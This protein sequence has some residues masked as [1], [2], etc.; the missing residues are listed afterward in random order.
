ML[1]HRSMLRCEDAGTSY[2]VLF[3]FAFCFAYGFILRGRYH[4]HLLCFISLLLSLFV[5]FLLL[6]LLL[7]LAEGGVKV[8]RDM[9]SNSS[10]T[11][12]QRQRQRHINAQ[13][14]TR[15]ASFNFSSSFSSISI[16]GLIFI[17][18][19]NFSCD[20][21][22]IS[23]WTVALP[24]RPSAR[25]SALPSAR[26]TWLQILDRVA[27]GA[28]RQRTLLPRVV[29][30]DSAASEAH[31]CHANVHVACCIARAA[32]ARWLSTNWPSCGAQI[33]HQTG[34]IHFES[35]YCLPTI[36]GKLQVNET[37]EVLK[38]TEG[39]RAE[40]CVEQSG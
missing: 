25:P 22:P 31:F 29:K 21:S 18:I 24:A 13:R 4:L 10:A 40:S 7:L 2:R 16:S 39:L 11:Q 33:Q 17:F 38:L 8:G 6:F 14:A 36:T 1:P 27:A 28:G 23:T 15:R 26:L 32:P 37:Y 30:R 35:F 19:F 3:C 5:Y 34:A 20:S 9:H 12:C